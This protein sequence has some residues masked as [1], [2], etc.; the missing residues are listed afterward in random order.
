M[1]TAYAARSAA[2]REK[3]RQALPLP[4]KRG[5]SR[6]EGADYVGVS[7]STFDE[8]VADGR[9]PQPKTINSRIVWDRWALD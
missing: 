1:P 6:L 8:M 4:E 9:M 2:V 5:L 3:G 7:P